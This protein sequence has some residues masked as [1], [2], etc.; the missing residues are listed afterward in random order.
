MVY[1][2]GAREDYDEWPEGWRWDDLTDDFAYLERKLQIHQRAPTQWT[3]ACIDA[4]TSCG[5]RHSHDFN[6]GDLSNAIG[7]EWMSYDGNQRRSSYVSFIRDAQ[8]GDKLEVRTGARARRIII[9]ANKRATGVEYE[10]NGVIATANARAEVIVCAGALETP[11]L[12][13]LSGLGPGS[14][15]RGVG[16]DVVADVPGVGQNLHD[17]PN[18]PVFFR[19][20]DTVDC[21][22]P[23]LYS[24]YRTLPQAPLPASQSDTCYVF[25][26]APSA[27]KEATQRMLPAQVLP[28]ALYQTAAKQMIRGGIEMAFKS[29]TVRELVNHLYGIVV[30]LGKPQSR[31][32]M[33]LRSRRSTRPC[34]HQPQLL[35]PLARHANHGGRGAGG[36]SPGRLGPVA[37]LRQQGADAAVV[38]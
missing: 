38:G 1:T 2:R 37:E 22:Y 24:F 11:K 14:S 6:D 31:G 30:I 33:H 7:Y 36:T 34:S 27:M 20:K 15:L 5:F 23:Q 3:K 19:C 9:D 10:L 4:A 28:E 25:W 35:R 32:Q 29:S 16:V 17:H 8:L 13:M 21:F 26:P 12:L 18:V